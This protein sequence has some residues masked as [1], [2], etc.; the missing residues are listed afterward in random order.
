MYIKNKNHAAMW[1]NCSIYCGQCCNQ[2][3]Q[4][5]QKNKNDVLVSDNY[6]IPR[7]SMDLEV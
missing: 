7:T 6:T 4:E 3:A 5:K 2:Y 1:V